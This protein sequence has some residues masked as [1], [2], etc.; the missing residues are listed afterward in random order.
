MKESPENDNLFRGLYTLMEGRPSA[1]Q[2]HSLSGE[3]DFEMEKLMRTKSASSV[4]VKPLLRRQRRGQ[5]ST[6]IT[7]LLDTEQALWI[8]TLN[9]S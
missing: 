2:L 5:G 1:H 3:A 4:S 6:Q 7:C 8:S 9:H